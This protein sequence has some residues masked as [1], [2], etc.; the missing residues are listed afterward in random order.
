M[1]TQLCRACFLP[2]AQIYTQTRP[3]SKTPKRE[4]ISLENIELI[5]HLVRRAAGERRGRETGRSD[6]TGR[7]VTKVKR[8]EGRNSG[9]REGRQVR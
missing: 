8:M 4:K 2:P 9:A 3:A 6:G 7:R 5:I 1:E